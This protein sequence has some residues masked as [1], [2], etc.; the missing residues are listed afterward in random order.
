[1][2][3]IDGNKDERIV[4]TS[5]V[6]A[7]DYREEIENDV[8]VLSKTQQYKATSSTKIDGGQKID[9]KATIAKIN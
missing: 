1:M 9:I 5:Y 2:I 7:K 4:N 8:V 6:S 3:D